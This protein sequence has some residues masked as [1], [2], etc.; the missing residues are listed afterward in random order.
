MMKR[1]Y[2]L[3]AGLVLT[4][5]AACAQRTTRP[6]AAAAVEAAEAETAAKGGVPA[7]RNVELPSGA[8][9]KV[10]PGWTVT[11]RDD[12]ATV[13][14]PE[15]QLVIEIVEIRGAADVPAAIEQAQ[16]QRKPGF[17]REVRNT[18]EKPG[19]DGW[20]SKVF[21]MY[22]TSPEEHRLVETDVYKKGDLAVV[23][24]DDAPLDHL[25]RREPQ[26]QLV[27]ESL[28]PPGHV[29]ESYSGREPAALDGERLAGLRRD[30]E[31][32]RR[33]ADVPGVAVALFDAD[34]VLMEEGF[35]VRRLGRDAPITPDTLFLVASMT[36]PLVSLLMARLVDE[37]RF[38]WD[39]QVTEIFPSFRLGDPETTSRVR[40]EHLV[41]ACTGLPRHDLEWFFSHGDS[42]PEQQLEIL[43]GMQPTT[44]FGELYQYSNPLVAAAG[45]IAAHQVV[46]DRQLGPAFDQAM[47]QWIFDPLGMKRTTF[48]FDEVLATDHAAPHA[49]DVELRNVPADFDLNRCILPVRPAGGAWS[50][51]RDYARYGRLELTRGQLP[52][53]SRFI[54]PDCLTARRRPMVRTG[55]NEW[56]GLGLQTEMIKGIRVLGHGGAMIG[57]TS[58]F[59]FLPD[60]GIGGVV[61]TNAQTGYPLAKAIRK[62]VLEVM[63]A[64]RAEAEEDLR[65]AIESIRDNVRAAKKDWRIPPDA[66]Q[67]ARLAA[68]Y[69]NEALGDIE[70]HRT[71]QNLI[72][73]YGSRQSRMA[74]E[75][76]PDGSTSFI[77]IDPGQLGIGFAAGEQ[78]G[79]IENL[80]LRT[81]QQTYTFAA[82]AAPAADEQ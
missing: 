63:F 72:F 21:R 17:D 67:V 50:S 54:A 64:G 46:P 34:G 38:G 12:G 74:T 40:V 20:E 66:K 30:I 55:E 29:R 78:S 73:S 76:N 45:Y 59:F 79:R 1:F 41:C 32:M 81:A 33:I 9:F 82:T 80:T 47:R 56:Y 6:A 71:E 49:L 44:D 69:H 68:V 3:T 57:F 77:T 24:M 5:S 11:E 13:V 51:I 28:L 43:A 26:Y 4:M 25:Q 7:D 53:G 48:S 8:T 61:L 60:H 70:V 75:Q 15:K 22:K 23:L 10:A 18:I 65:A 58:D 36:K 42:S 31:R 14:G 16:Q 19:R 2:L 52:D 35:G 39:T 37:G 27:Y 62:R